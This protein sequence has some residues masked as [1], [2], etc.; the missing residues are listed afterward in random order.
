MLLKTII[1]ICKM[2]LVFFAVVSP[3]LVFVFAFWLYWRFIGKIKPI[4]NE[5]GRF[6]E[7]NIFRRLFIDFPKQL[8]HDL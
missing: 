4:K 5:K 3:F 8:A 2:F 7:H 1:F 6:K